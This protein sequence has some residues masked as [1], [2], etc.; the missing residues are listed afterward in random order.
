M[1]V[2]GSDRSAGARF[3][4]LGKGIIPPAPD[5]IP[6]DAGAHLNAP[7]KFRQAGT[8]AEARAPHHVSQRGRGPGARG[9]LK[10]IEPRR[11]PGV[12]VAARIGFPWDREILYHAAGPTERD[13][14]ASHEQSSA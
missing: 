7:L 10:K 5:R 13:T 6:G 2:G 4:G 12:V 14:V 8:L 1:I 11:G 9:G 3:R